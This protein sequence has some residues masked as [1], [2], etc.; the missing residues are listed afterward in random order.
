MRPER[1]IKAVA[2]RTGVTVE[3]L[4]R[5]D[6]HRGNGPASIKRAQARQLAA[7]L[8]RYGL[9]LRL[10]EIAAVL[11]Y[12]ETSA[13]THAVTRADELRTTNQPW[14]VET[15]TLLGVVLIKTGKLNPTTLLPH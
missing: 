15:S 2:K 5:T 10:R 3:D 1:I 8:L 9:G 13:A 7:W 12:S 11:G 4:T 6:G 14:R